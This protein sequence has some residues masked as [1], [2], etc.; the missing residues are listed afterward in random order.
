MKT[1]TGG[2]V[3]SRQN[4]ND[5]NSNFSPAPVSVTAGAISLTAALHAGGTTVLNLAGGVAVTLPAATGSG[6]RY[7][8]V[9]GTAS[10]ANTIATLPVTDFFRGGVIINDSGDSAA[11]TADFFPAASTSNK[12]S[13]TTVGGGGA[14][15]D[16]VL[17]EDFAA[18]LWLVSGVY[19]TAA[20]A[21]TPFSHV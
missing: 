16:W 15:G 10:N 1:I 18:G 5:L 6:S 2:G 3:L 7:R 9:V 12:M 14:V 4:V 19:Q 20:D 11:G 21:V 17:L 13:P 8:I